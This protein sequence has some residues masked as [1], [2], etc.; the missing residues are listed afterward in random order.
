MRSD[1]EIVVTLSDELLGHL[2]GLAAVLE[3]PFDWLVAG[4]ICDTLERASQNVHFSARQAL[5]TRTRTVT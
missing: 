1:R 2:R 5:A 4:I 3:V